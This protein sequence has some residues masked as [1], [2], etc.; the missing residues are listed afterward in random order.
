MLLESPG[1]GSSRRLEAEQQWLHPSR[2]TARPGTC[3]PQERG[4]R[5]LFC[6]ETLK[7]RN[8]PPRIAGVSY[9]LCERERRQRPSCH[10]QRKQSAGFP[11]S[12]FLS[13]FF[14]SSHAFLS[15]SS[16]RLLFSSLF[17]SISIW[18]IKQASDWKTDKKLLV[19]WAGQN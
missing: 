16:F 18:G 3:C 2:L 5:W 9:R 8:S 15:C 12:R 11:L 4:S 14:I 10:P 1:G 13:V 7:P 6:L 19:L 17:L